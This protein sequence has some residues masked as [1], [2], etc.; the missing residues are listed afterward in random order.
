[1]LSLQGLA[2]ARRLGDTTPDAGRPARHT[3]LGAP[4]KPNFWSISWPVSPL[5]A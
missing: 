4:N 3:P 5:C 1:M 2:A